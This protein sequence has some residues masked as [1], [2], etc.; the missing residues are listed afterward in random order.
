MCPRLISVVTRHVKQFN[1]VVHI[2]AARN[3]FLEINEVFF[4]P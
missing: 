2:S 3:V 1:S 4:S